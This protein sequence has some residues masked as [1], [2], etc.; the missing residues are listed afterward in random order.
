MVGF[1]SIRLGFL[2][3][4]LLELVELSLPDKLIDQVLKFY[5]GVRRMGVLLIIVAGVSLVGRFDE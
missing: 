4:I 5:V 3:H 2:F 1:E